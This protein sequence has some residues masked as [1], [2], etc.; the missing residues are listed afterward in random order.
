[1]SYISC[2]N[3]YVV[4]SHNRR[5][6]S[7]SPSIQLSASSFSDRPLISFKSL[8]RVDTCECGIINGHCA[9]L[10]PFLECKQHQAANRQDKRACSVDAHNSLSRKKIA[11]S[12][13]HRSAIFS[14][15]RV[16]QRA[17]ISWICDRGGGDFKCGE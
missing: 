10:P 14:S 8:S 1:M 15:Q 5:H 9:S 6:Q 11:H 12:R 2:S 16:Y 3:F 4:L 7:T 13:V 17:P